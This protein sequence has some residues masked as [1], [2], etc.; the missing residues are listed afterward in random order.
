[1]LVTKDG[2]KCIVYDGKHFKEAP[3]KQE[4]ALALSKCTDAGRWPNI[5]NNQYVKPSRN[6]VEAASGEVDLANLKKS[7]YS[8]EQLERAARKYWKATDTD[9]PTPLIGGNGNFAYSFEDTIGKKYRLTNTEMFIVLWEAI[10]YKLAA[11]EILRLDR[12]AKAARSKVK[13]TPKEDRKSAE[14]AEK[15]AQDAR[16]NLLK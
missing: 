4:I 12:L 14:A 10:R 5:S 8:I 9:C 11:K 3:T 6:Q 2:V 13:S 1:V 16:K 15:A 7:T